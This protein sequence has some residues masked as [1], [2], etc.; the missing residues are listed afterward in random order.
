VPV[1]SVWWRWLV[2]LALAATWPRRAAVAELDPSGGDLAL[3]L[4]SPAGRYVLAPRP[5]LLTWA[6]AAQSGAAATVFWAHCQMAGGL[7]AV[8]LGAA[9][10]EQSIGLGPLWPDLARALTT[11][12][13]GD[14]VADLGRLLSASPILPV[15][16]AADIVVVTTRPTIDGLVHARDRA[17][18]LVNHLRRAGGPAG[19][20]PRVELLVI[21]S[22]RHGPAAVG[23]AQAV[24]ER[25][26][27]PV[28]VVGFLA[29]DPAG[30]AS[31]YAGSATRRPVRSLLIRTARQIGARL[32]AMLA[33]RDASAGHSGRSALRV[34]PV[35][36]TVEVRR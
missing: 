17:R 8:L 24:V 4:T 15:V 3:R 23:A 18:A 2:A 25:D 29:W 12:D 30:V 9:G 27:L 6:A 32:H 20:E 21:A 19:V 1:R 34:E 35:Q 13:D 5:C 10:A 11:I 7:P 28:G 26:G 22:D 31:L 33:E 36:P 16:A 14:I